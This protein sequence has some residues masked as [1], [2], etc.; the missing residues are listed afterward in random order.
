MKKHTYI[1]ASDKCEHWDSSKFGMH[2]TFFGNNMNDVCFKYYAPGCGKCPK[3][4]TSEE[5]E[6]ILGGTI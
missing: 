3:E 4:M 1:D 5:I 6:T 2:C